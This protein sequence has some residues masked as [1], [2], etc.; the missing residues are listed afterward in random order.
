MSELH[1]RKGLTDADHCLKLPHSDRNAVARV[2]Q[3]LLFVGLCT[4]SH[5]QS[6]QFLSSQGGKTRVDLC[7]CIANVLLEQF[8]GQLIGLCFAGDSALV[9]VE[10]VRGYSRIVLCSIQVSDYEDAIEARKDGGLKLDLFSNL[11][12]LIIPTVDRIGSC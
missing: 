10:D 2:S 6:L 4:I 3:L 12:E 11:L 9:Q 1:P 5:V 8:E 7:L